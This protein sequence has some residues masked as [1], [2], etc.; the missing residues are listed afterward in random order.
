MSREN[1]FSSLKEMEE[2]HHEAHQ[3]FQDAL[4]ANDM[5]GRDV[6]NE[7]WPRRLKHGHT[8]KPVSKSQESAEEMRL[9]AERKKVLEMELELERLR[10][11]KK[12]P[13]QKDNGAG[14]EKKTS[15]KAIGL[16]QERK[17]ATKAKVVEEKPAKKAR[18]GNRK[19]TK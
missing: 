18:K 8:F 9:L 19:T 5:Q 11:G 4:T 1:T 13:A 15:R 7:D 16:G 12:A 17:K 3:E 14:A 2:H 10:S 6:G